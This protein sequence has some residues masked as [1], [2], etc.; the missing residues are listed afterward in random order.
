MSATRKHPALDPRT[1][2]ALLDCSRRYRI[3]DAAAYL[4]ISRAKLYVDIRAGKLVT[5]KD[6]KRH[7]VPGSEIARLSRVPA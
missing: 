2:S 5:I 4:G 3:D 7:F 1:P 6:G